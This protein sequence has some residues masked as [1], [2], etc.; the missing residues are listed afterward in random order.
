MSDTSTLRRHFLAEPLTVRNE[1]R[2][3]P[4]WHRGRPH[5]LLWA[6][7][8]DTPALRERVAMAQDALD[9]LLLGGYRRQLHVT[10]A[11]CGF[12]ARDRTP[13]ADEF[14][15]RLIVRQ[16]G[17]LTAAGVG[18]FD[19]AIGGLESFSSAPFLSVQDDGDALATLRRCLHL[20]GPHPQG[21]YVPHV[22]VGLYADAW[23]T[24][25]VARRFAALDAAP[26]IGCR[27]TRLSLMGYVAAEIGGALFTLADYRLDSGRLH[28]HAA[29]AACLGTLPSDA[30][31]ASP[32]ALPTAAARA[33]HHGAEVS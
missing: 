10:V 8:V 31:A 13:A 18:A 25:E 22:T 3:F 21:R 15:P 2:D 12:P 17:A 16:A 4:D 24:A 33:D 6:L 28:W 9:G 30:E 20:D 27:I 23:P 11:L 7:D 14:D 19:I 32:Q 29:A 5:Y 1:R 26:G